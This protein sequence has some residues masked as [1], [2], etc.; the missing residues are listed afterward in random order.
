[1][2]CATL[3]IM[4]LDEGR[5]FRRSGTHLAV[6]AWIRSAP[7]E[8]LHALFDF[9]MN[10]SPCLV[11]FSGDDSEKVHDEFDDEILAR[12]LPYAITAFFRGGLETDWLEFNDID[13]ESG[14]VDEIVL[15]PVGS[16]PEVDNLMRIEIEKLTKM[17]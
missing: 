17:R 12:D 3:K 13:C 8:R 1:M 14:P 15:I 2:M 11:G 16:N 10:R 5:H 6:F 7:E 9:I 4:T